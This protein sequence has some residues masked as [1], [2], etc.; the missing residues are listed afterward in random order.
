MNFY[1]PYFLLLILFSSV[2]TYAQVP[3]EKMQAVYEE[4]KTPFTYGL[5]IAPQNDSFKVDCPTLFRKGKNWYM[6]YIQFNGKGYETWLAKSRDL[7]NW[8]TLGRIL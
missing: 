2:K 7:L 1:R 5:V 4:I 8:Q 3:L 6:T